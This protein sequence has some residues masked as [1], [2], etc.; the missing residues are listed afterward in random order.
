MKLGETPVLETTPYM[1]NE[2]RRLSLGRNAVHFGSMLLPVANRQRRRPVLRSFACRGIINGGH[3]MPKSTGRKRRKREAER[4]EQAQ[5]ANQEVQGP[6]NVGEI[7]RLFS[8]LL[9][10]LM[11]IG[12]LSRRSV[13]GLAL[14]A[15]G[16]ALLYRGTTGHCQVYESLGLDTN[17][18]TIHTARSIDR[19]PEATRQGTSTNAQGSSMEPQ[20]DQPMKTMYRRKGMGKAAMV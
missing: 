12:G 16:A 5:N 19:A 10:G 3:K 2:T 1:K 14:A 11:L 6:Q 7:E 13:P 17:H 9:G 8:S 4:Q 15:R 18:G 20:A